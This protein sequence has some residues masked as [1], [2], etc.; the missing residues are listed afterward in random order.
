MNE[1]GWLL[2]VRCGGCGITL[3][4]EVWLWI[5]IPSLGRVKETFWVWFIYKVDRLI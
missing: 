3:F 2:L 1:F 5:T 4:L